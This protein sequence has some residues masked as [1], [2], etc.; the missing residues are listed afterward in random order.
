[1][2]ARLLDETRRYPNGRE[3]RIRARYCKRCQELI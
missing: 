3:R 2:G 1:V